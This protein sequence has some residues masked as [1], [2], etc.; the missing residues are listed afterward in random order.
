MTVA[1]NLEKLAALGL[2]VL[3]AGAAACGSSAP[4]AAS[5]TPPVTSIPP[6]SSTGGPSAEIWHPTPKTTWQWQLSGPID[7]SVDAEMFDVDLFETPAS[8]ITE[9]HRE[10]RIVVCYLSAGA[11]EVF[12]PDADDFPQSVLGEPNGW[13]GERW[14]DIRRLDVLAP[15]IEARLDLCREK[16]FDGVEVDNID[17]YT[18]ETGFPLV[19]ADQLAFNTFLADAAH[20]RGLSIGLKNDVEQA[21]ILEPLFDWAINEECALYDECGLLLPFIEAGKAVFHVE[22]DLETS[23]FCPLTDDLG[24]SSMR[25][26]PEL[27]AWREYCPGASSG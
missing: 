9:L 17:G 6:T 7:T 22:Y 1:Q 27:D 18:N 16:G 14:L 20:H 10:G 5:S 23:E 3:M 13:P 19:A 8:T 24:F 26:L 21:A 12:R 4:V 11:W 2:A 15:I 25:K